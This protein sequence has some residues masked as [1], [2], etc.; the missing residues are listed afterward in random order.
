MRPGFMVFQ[1][2][3][4]PNPA[5]GTRSSSSKPMFSPP[6]KLLHVCH[7]AFT[8]FPLGLSSVSFAQETQGCRLVVWNRQQTRET[9]LFWQSHSRVD[10]KMVPRPLISP[11][12]HDFKPPA[13]QEW[14]NSQAIGDVHISGHML[15]Q[16][17][18]IRSYFLR[19]SFLRFLERLLRVRNILDC[20]YF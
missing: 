16:Y 18:I 8:L 20:Y 7:M 17:R 14:C 12:L 19:A 5:S 2:G 6:W 9:R 15:S 1:M 13:P 3:Q 4:W 11:N 10:F